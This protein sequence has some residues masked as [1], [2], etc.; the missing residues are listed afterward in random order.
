M[1][2]D[3]SHVQPYSQHENYVS[4]QKTI[5][6]FRRIFTDE[7]IDG[8]KFDAAFNGFAVDSM[9]RRFTHQA[10]KEAGLD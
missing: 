2:N 7:G 1:E 3:S 4:H 5:K 9:V 10:V 8:S 6:S